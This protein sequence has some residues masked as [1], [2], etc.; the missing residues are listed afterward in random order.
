M[1]E[2]RKKNNTTNREIAGE[3]KIFGK[4]LR[5]VE[6]KTK[7]ERSGKSARKVERNARRKNEEEERGEEKRFRVRTT[8]T[9]LGDGRQCEWQ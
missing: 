9:R 5:R 6:R 3:E 2:G 4:S 7:G 8:R 1:N